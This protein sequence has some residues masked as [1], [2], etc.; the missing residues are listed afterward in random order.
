MAN[1]I[2][3]LFLLISLILLLSNCG[4]K[5]Q[6]GAAGGPG[7]PPPVQITEFEV[8]SVQA[9]YFDEYPAVLRSIN[10]VDLRAA[11]T[12]FIN[13][14]DEPEQAP[15]SIAY[16]EQMNSEGSP[17]EIVAAGYVW[18]PGTELV[19]RKTIFAKGAGA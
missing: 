2:T 18:T 12:R 19:E 17:S 9:N 15:A 1:L 11:G 4:G 6:A 3:K 8:K 13:V 10:E 5:Q 14:E 16:R 7:A